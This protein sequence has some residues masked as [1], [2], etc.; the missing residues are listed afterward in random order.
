MAEQTAARIGVKWGWDLGET[1]WKTGMDSNLIMFDSLFEI[2]V[3]DRDLT[4]PPGGESN[5]DNYLIASG[6]TG[7]WSGYDDHVASYQNGGW[8]FYEPL[9]GWRCSLEDENDSIVF[10]NGT[11]WIEDYHMVDG[12]NFVF[13]TSNGTEIGTSDTQLLAFWG[14]APIVQP[15][16]VDQTAVIMDNADED[17]GGLTIS[18]SYDQAEVEA[19]RDQAEVL[20]DD[21]REINVLVTAIRAA[22][23]AEG[24]IKG[25]A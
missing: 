5:G 19:L 7:D 1:E 18:A 17:I 22:L 21:T 13:G 24:L 15:S 25:S 16:S 23:V 11:A 4:A 6:A 14:A 12:G 2:S 8:F 3:I 10:Y 20:A 9:Q